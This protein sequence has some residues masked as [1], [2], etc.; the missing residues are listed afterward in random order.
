MGN[1]HRSVLTKRE[2][3]VMEVVYREKHISA[4]QLWKHIPD[5]PSY[6]AVRSVLSILE[7]KSLLKHSMEGRK[8]IYSPAV[9]H[10]KVAVSAVKQLLRTYF[11]N[12]LDNAVAAMLELHENDMNEDDYKRLYKIID[13]SKGEEKSNASD[14]T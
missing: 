2:Q 8:F 14:D 3:Q 11:D 10:S 9:E 1:E 5:F 7:Q 4:K 13:R 12:S 6:S